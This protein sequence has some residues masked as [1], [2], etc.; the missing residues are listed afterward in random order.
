MRKEQEK[1]VFETRNEEHEIDESIEL[2]EEVEKT[3]PVIRIFERVRKP[4]ERYIRLISILHL[5]YLPLM[6]I[7]CRL[8]I[9]STR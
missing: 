7:P 4:I 9:H 5:C 1:L 6:R 2:E 3:T 8:G